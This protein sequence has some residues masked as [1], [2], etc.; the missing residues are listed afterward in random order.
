MLL[1][2]D[3]KKRWVNGSIGII[4]QLSDTDI[5]VEINGCTYPIRRAR[6]EVIEYG[7]HPREKRIEAI[8]VGSFSQ[9]PVKPAW[10]ITIHKS[11]GL[12]FDRI[13]IDLGAGAFAHGQIYVALSRC[14]SLEGLI[15]TKPV[16]A[17]DIILDEKVKHYIQSKKRNQ[18]FLN[19]PLA[20]HPTECLK[21]LDRIRWSSIVVG[22]NTN[23]GPV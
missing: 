19:S 5:S 12:T 14:T 13:I 21:G 1:K 9:F 6:W 11:Q 23:N 18:S 10:A 16:R 22:V 7:Y 4:R 2:N 20:L 15:L 17:Q 3:P 8:A